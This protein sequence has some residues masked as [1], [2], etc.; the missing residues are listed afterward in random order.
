MSVEKKTFEFEAWQVDLETQESYRERITKA[1]DEFLDELAEG[2]QLPA[3][4]DENKE[5][6]EAEQ[7]PA[8]PAE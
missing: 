3:D 6:A 1:F 8:D 2:A 4:G 5:D 7:L